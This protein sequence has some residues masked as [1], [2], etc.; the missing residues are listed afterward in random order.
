MK[1]IYDTEN[2]DLKVKSGN[3]LLDI[4]LD[5]KIPLSHSCEGM[6]SCGTCRVIITS[7]VDDLPQTNHLEQE[8]ASDRGFGPEERLACQLYPTKDISFKLPQD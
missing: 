7:S 4:C 3:H 1:V 6:A 8:M 2:L 5:N